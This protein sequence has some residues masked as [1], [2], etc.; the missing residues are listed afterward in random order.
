MLML[1]AAG[2]QA[3]RPVA[4]QGPIIAETSDRAGPRRLDHRAHRH[5]AC[6]VAPKPS[7]QLA[8]PQ[9]D[10][11]WTVADVTELDLVTAHIGGSRDLRCL[12]L[13]TSRG[14][15]IAAMSVSGRLAGFQAA[16]R[17]DRGLPGIY[18][19]APAMYAATIYVA[20]RSKDARAR[21]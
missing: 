19:A 13:V 3:D 5:Y 2:S 21:S 16:R 11:I 10:L 15:F 14:G 18:R 12:H 8:H 7:P 17:N 4:V 6:A 1:T 20:C 9:N